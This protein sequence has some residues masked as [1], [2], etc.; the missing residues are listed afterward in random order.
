MDFI[1]YRFKKILS[2]LFFEEIISIGKILLFEALMACQI[3]YRISF[4][5]ILVNLNII[6]CQIGLLFY[7]SGEIISEFKNKYPKIKIKYILDK[8]GTYPQ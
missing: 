5:W 7:F 1:E 6:L 3:I 2:V 4:D 8:K